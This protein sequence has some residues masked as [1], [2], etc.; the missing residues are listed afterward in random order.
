MIKVQDFCSREGKSVAELFSSPL[1][2]RG[3]GTGFFGAIFNPLRKQ[4]EGFLFHDEPRAVE[5]RG[6]L[7]KFMVHLVRRS[8]E[9]NHER[10]LLV[11]LRKDCAAHLPE[12]I[13]PSQRSI[14][15]CHIG[16]SNPG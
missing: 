14:L 11:R 4:L 16:I 15:G 7:S 12:D 3:G 13:K 10:W 5:A 8:E 2:I 6:T 9:G 1:A